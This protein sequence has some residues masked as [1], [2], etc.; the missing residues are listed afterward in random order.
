VLKAVR[1]ESVHRG[2]LKPQPTDLHTRYCDRRQQHHPT[3]YDLPLVR[4]RTG[5]HTAVSELGF[6]SCVP[7][8]RFGVLVL[9][10][11]HWSEKGMGGFI[12]NR[13]G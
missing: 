12:V 1:A 2:G 11:C 9:V 8:E 10:A 4:K 7:C 3:R 13:K 5:G 6:M